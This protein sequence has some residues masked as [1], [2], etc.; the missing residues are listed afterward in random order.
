MQARA[1]T[2]GGEVSIASA[3]D[4]GTTIALRVPVGRTR[5]FPWRTPSK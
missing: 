3:A 2:L 1:K 4:R 5:A